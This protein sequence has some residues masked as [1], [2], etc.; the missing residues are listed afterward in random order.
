MNSDDSSSEEEYDILPRPRD[1]EEEVLDEELSSSEKEEETPQQEVSSAKTEEDILSKKEIKYNNKPLCKRF[2]FRFCMYVHYDYTDTESIENF[3]QYLSNAISNFYELDDYKLYIFYNKEE[4]DRI[5]VFC[6]DIITDIKTVLNIK[7]YINCE[8]FEKLGHKPRRNII[9][10]PDTMYT[11]PVSPNIFLPN[12]FDIGKN[13]TEDRKTYFCL[14]DKKMKSDE[15]EKLMLYWSMDENLDITPYSKRYEEYIELHDGKEEY[16]DDLLID[17][18]ITEDVKKKIEKYYTKCIEY[19]KKF[20]P[21]STLNKVLSLDNNVYLFDFSKSNRECQL[22]NLVHK[23][24]RQYLT[25]SLFTK[26]AKYK[27]H[28]T[29]ASDKSKSISFKIDFCSNDNTI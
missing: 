1:V 5:R 24:N 21:D 17:K 29:D 20:H 19:F 2:S 6:P 4:I 28:D 22:C 3:E 11:L 12:L 14:N 25:F 16:K 18:D 15:I 9:F 7:R 8:I 26:T 13:K 10:I 23:S 27:C